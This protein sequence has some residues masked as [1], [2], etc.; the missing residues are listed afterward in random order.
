MRMPLE[1][2]REIGW[3]DQMY[4][5][6]RKRGVTIFAYVPD[7][8]HK[9][10]IER[11]IADADLTA[12]PLTSDAILTMRGDFGEANPWPYAI[13]ETATPTKARTCSD[14]HCSADAETGIRK[15]LRA[16][17]PAPHHYTR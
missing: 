12:V 4:D 6:L 14:A 11:A 9:I 1:R 7:A 5:L 16:L 10:A 17:S 8:G 15:I 3:Q 2:A 13:A